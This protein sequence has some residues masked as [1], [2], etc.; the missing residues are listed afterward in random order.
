MLVTYYGPGPVLSASHA[1]SYLT[2]T[3][4]LY[5]IININLSMSI[6]ILFVTLHIA[7]QAE[8]NYFRN[9]LIL[10][11]MLAWVPR[12]LNSILFF[13]DGKTFNK[14]YIIKCEFGSKFKKT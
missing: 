1:M 8:T 2:C 3:I 13:L 10:T 12:P 5:T 14:S 6:K 11:I 9:C 4:L 7:S